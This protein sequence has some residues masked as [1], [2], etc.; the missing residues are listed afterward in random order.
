VSGRSRL[1]FQQMIDLDLAY[2]G[3]WSLGLDL[4]ILVRTPLVVLLGEGAC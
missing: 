1:S 3:R 4:L 2:I